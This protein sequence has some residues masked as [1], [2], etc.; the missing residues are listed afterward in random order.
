MKQFFKYVFATITGILI[1]ML[2]SFLIM[3]ISLM[4]MTSKS[5]VKVKD[6]SV[7][8][9]NLSG[10]LNERSEDNP[11]MSLFGSSAAQKLSL[12]NI[13]KSIKRAKE[14]EKIKG[15]YIQSGVLSGASPA[16]L[17][18]IHDA[19]SDFK[20]SKKFILA[21][22]DNYTL[23]TYY[24]SSLADSVV[25]NPYGMIEWNGMSA[26][27]MYMKEALDKLGVKVE[28]FKVGSYKSAV[29]PF[30]QNEMSDANREQLTVFTDEVWNH[31][32]TSVG[33]S[34]KISSSQLD[35]LADSMITFSATPDEYK[36]MG[37]VDKCAYSDEVPEIL[38]HMMDVE[39]DEYNKI[40]C[41]DLAA[42][43]SDEPKGTS[44]DIIAVYYA[45]GDIVDEMAS[46]F[47]GGH[48]I[49]GQEVCKDLQGLADD[50]HVKA[51]VL[52]VNSGGGS[53][54]ASE[55]I[56]HSI[57]QLKLKKPVVVSMGGYAASGGYYISSGAN[58]IV[59]EPTTLTGSIGIFGM[60]PIAKE[61]LNEKLGIHYETVKT[62][63][64]S[65]FGDFS[66]EMSESEKHHLQGYINRG[67]ELFTQRCSQGRHVSQDSI[68]S[69]GEGRIWTGVHAKKIGLV[70]ELGNLETAISK[71]KSLS[72]LED[73]TLL[74]YPAKK[75]FF[76]NLFN[77][78]SDD[79]YASAKMEEALGEYYCIFQTLRHL[80]PKGNVQAALPYKLKFNL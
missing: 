72:K 33:K 53:A 15:I 10:V 23:G 19:L 61:L 13:L 70:D 41:E 52:R 80:N 24:L 65:D 12:E 48:E 75:S 5:I 69:I 45:Y 28:V 51:V 59:A 9:L 57:E 47:G 50:E 66:R 8:E 37:L 1:L 67:Y 31:Y 42:S 32:K 56:W 77:S 18:E 46:G 20:K 68:K 73:Y 29:E 27:T 49:V 25:I 54:Y 43:V 60:F 79:S 17:E 11:L 2:L 74:T 14:D 55:Q 64:F 40:S 26:T 62:N 22:G 6:N 39:K 7:L 78:M 35:V 16:M 30:L 38:S 58:W 34:R 44:G 63:E 76:D 36:K 71:A 21:Y 3:V 4:S